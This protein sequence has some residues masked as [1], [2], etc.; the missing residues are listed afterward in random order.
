MQASPIVS[1]FDFWIPQAIVLLGLLITYS[2]IRRDRRKEA[3]AQ[4]IRHEQ[5]IA[6]L[7]SLR[8]FQNTQI[9]LNDAHSKQISEL[10]VQTAQLT[11]IVRGQNRRLIMLEDRH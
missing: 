11:E 9:L 5:N 8:E 6:R 1:R 4:L 2:S 10:K 7:D 3:D